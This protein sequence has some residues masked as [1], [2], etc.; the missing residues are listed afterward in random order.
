MNI[1]I[2]QFISNLSTGDVWIGFLMLAI[3]YALKK[4]PLKVFA[5]FNQRKTKDIDQAKALLESDKLG[6]EANELLREYLEHYSFK[7][8]YG[9]N[10]NR[11]MRSALLK[12]YQNFQGKFG[13]QELKSAYPYMKLDGSIIKIR[14]H[15]TS[16]LWRWVVTCLSWFIGLYSL[17]IIVLVVFTKT[18]SK[19]QFFALTFLSVALLVTAMLFSSI[20]WPYHSAIKIQGLIE[21]S[22]TKKSSRR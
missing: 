22:L 14:L 17:L 3:F 12:F 16:H 5:H 8:F 18:D 13:W 19:I 10:A 7:R 1:L 15:W 20:N 2:E 6:K 9:I 4:E 21:G 11:D